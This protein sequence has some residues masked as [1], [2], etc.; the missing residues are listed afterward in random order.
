MTPTDVN[1]EEK[2]NPSKVSNI[3][4]SDTDLKNVSKLVCTAWGLHPLLILIWITQP[5][6]V[7]IVDN[8]DT[9]LTER[10]ST[11]STRPEV[12][13]KLAELD[14][15]INTD[16][17]NIKIYLAEKYTKKN[18]P[19]YYA[20]FGIVK[21]GKVFK[22]PKDRDERKDALDLMLPAITLHGF[23]SKP[24]GLAYWTNVKTQYDALLAQATSIDG[25]VSIKV[26]DKNVLKIQIK[27]VL[28]A[29]INLIKANYPDTYKSELRNW[30]F[31]KEKY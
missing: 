3:P 4:D 23:D 2:K 14:M 8:F 15:T 17:E 7:I 10:K 22:L 13:H 28:N 19:S 26:G 1:P 5:D 21:T 16:V 30:G 31:Q 6:F 9:T 24:F 20:A 12:S 29:I 18:A 25:T 11:G 27:K